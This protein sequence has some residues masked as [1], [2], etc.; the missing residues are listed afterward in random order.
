MKLLAALISVLFLTSASARAADVLVFAAASTTDALNEVA[1][2]FAAKGMGHVRSSYAASSTL[3]KQIER[4][5]PADI[6]LSADLQWMDYLQDRKLIV[7]GSRANLF[8]NTLVLIA[9]AGARTA[10]IKLDDLARLLGDGRLATGDP[11]HVPVGLYARQALEKLGQW[12]AVEPRLARAGSVRAA[13]AL[14]ERGEAPFGIVYATDAAASGKVKVVAAF[15]AALH[16]PIVYPVALVAGHETPAAKD[17]LAFLAS[18][19]AKG[20][21]VRHG[22]KLN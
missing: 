18:A 9:P 17:F 16:D 8:G 14:V 6:F 1:E 12:Q 21:F 15:P 2:M 3:A 10:E 5:A 7:A 22:F 20:V 19:E 4:G 13:M 11:D